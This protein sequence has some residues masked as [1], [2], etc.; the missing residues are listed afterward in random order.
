M[1][2]GGRA[3]LTGGQADGRAASVVPPA[4]SGDPQAPGDLKPGSGQHAPP[5]PAMGGSWPDS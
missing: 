2:A 5:P 3:G 4:R 1:A